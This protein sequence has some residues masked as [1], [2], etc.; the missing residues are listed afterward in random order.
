MF[1]NLHIN[2]SKQEIFAKSGNIL[3]LC[4]V[5][6]L[7]LVRLTRFDNLNLVRLTRFDNLNLV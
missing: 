3:Y 7:N 6:N 1:Y 4:N 5:N 2:I